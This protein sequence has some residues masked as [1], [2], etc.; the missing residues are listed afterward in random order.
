MVSNNNQEI[1]KDDTDMN[2]VESI[3]KQKLEWALQ[4]EK[5]ISKF[6][7]FNFPDRK[8]TIVNRYRTN[9]EI[10]KLLDS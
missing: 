4:D 8:E 2:L 1:I 5:C 7:P 6:A 3:H 9:I 10:E